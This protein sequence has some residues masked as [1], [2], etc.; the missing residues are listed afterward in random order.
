MATACCE[1]IRI[2]SAKPRSSITSAST[3]YI[4][5]MRL[6]STLESHSFQM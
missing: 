2:A 3:M 1:R 5:P 6:W 4:T